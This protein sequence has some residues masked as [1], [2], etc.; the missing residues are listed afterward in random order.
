MNTK[1]FAL[2]SATLLTVYA[3]F[4]ARGEILKEGRGRLGLPP[5]QAPR[6]Y[7]G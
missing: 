7:S 1:L 4:Q 3:A 2:V 5:L 6:R